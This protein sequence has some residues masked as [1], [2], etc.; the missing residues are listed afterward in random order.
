[1]HAGSSFEDKEHMET[2]VNLNLFLLLLSVLFFGG[3]VGWGVT[4]ISN[5]HWEHRLSKAKEMRDMRPL[6]FYD[7]LC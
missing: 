2:F 7:L 4:I 1:M 5:H 6:Y 3:L